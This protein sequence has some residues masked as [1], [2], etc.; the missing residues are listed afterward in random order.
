MEKKRVILIKSNL[1]EQDIIRLPK[2]IKALKREGYKIT[3]LGWDRQ[4]KVPLF[5]QKEQEDDCRQIRLGLKAPWGIKILPFLPIWWFFV[6]FKLMVTRWD[7]A[8]ATNFDSIIPTVIAGR[9]KRKPV[10]YEIVDVYA[11]MVLLPKII[12]DTGIRLDKLFIRFADAVIVIDEAQIQGFGEIPNSKIVP[13]YDTP[14]DTFDKIDVT[15]QKNETFTLFYA[16]FFCKARRMNLD[17]VISAIKNIDNVK[18][19]IAG[20]GDQVDEI[21]EWSR[22]MPDKIEFL[23]FISHEEVFQRSSTA[24]VLIVARTPVIPGNKYN[25]GSTF[26]RAM[27]C[28]RPFLANKDTATADKVCK[29][30]CGLVVDANNIEEIKE[31]IVKLKENPELC[32]E[33]GANAR[34]AYEQRYR[35]EIME[36]RLIGL[37]KEIDGELG[38]QTKRRNRKHSGEAK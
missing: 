15:Q 20:Y 32:K 12:R 2:E 28:G 5:P 7:I 22:K 37:Y 16:G 23:G 13:I 10:I 3:F 14:P 34:K 21:E 38:R 30:N 18:L 35:W 27:M 24:N 36:Q 31:A 25:C 19:V 33:F 6:F 1:I 8:H 26:L 29:E 11:D 4:C 17:K 9:L